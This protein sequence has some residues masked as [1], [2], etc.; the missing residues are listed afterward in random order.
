MRKNA[1]ISP[2]RQQSRSNSLKMKRSRKYE[3]NLLRSKRKSR[4]PPPN[5]QTKTR[6]QRQMATR[7]PSS[8]PTARKRAS[9]R[10]TLKLPSTRK[11]SKGG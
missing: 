8:C 3:L 11:T 10:R 9:R 2:K 6:R 5:R 7:I 4:K 1:R